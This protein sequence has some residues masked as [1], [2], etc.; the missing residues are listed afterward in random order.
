MVQ[1]ALVLGAKGR[2]GR[3]ACQAFRDAEWQVRAFVRPGGASTVGDG[4]MVVEGDAF[5][6]AAVAAAAE[7]A[8]V[9]VNALNPPYPAWP[10]DLPR[11]TTS[12]ITAAK[13][14]GA[15]VIFPGNVYNY[16]EDMPARL[17]EETP[18]RPTSKKGRLREDM[19]RTY[20]A[21]AAD[22]VRTLILRAGDFIERETTGNWFDSHIAAKVRE[23][24][25]LYPGPLDRVHAWA[26]LPDAAR[27]VAALAQKRATFAPFETF[28]FEGFALTGQEL[29]DALARAA[30]RTL[31]VQGMPWPMMR[32]LGLVSPDVREVVE[33]AYL[34]RVPHAIDGAKLR[35]VLPDF[36]PTPVDEAIAASLP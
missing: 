34:W 15:T 24:R 4:V 8:D 7:G 32:L 31:K 23:G 33:M 27:A 36:R 12:V 16:G 25:A 26:C 1:T 18:H 11:F 21:A 30:G 13:A 17:T 22:G 19:E 29:I 28:G 10:R 20:Q 14:S 35:G 5:D 9:I 3:A 2:F 6:P